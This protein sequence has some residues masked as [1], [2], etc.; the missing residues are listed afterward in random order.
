MSDAANRQELLTFRF[1]VTGAAYN[2]YPST[3][4]RALDETFEV[5]AESPGSALDKLANASGMW[6]V[7]DMDEPFEIEFLGWAGK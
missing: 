5:E 6:D 7:L 2:P 3:V 4:V 1:R